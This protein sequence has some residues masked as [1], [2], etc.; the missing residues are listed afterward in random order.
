M[1]TS[2]DGTAAPVWG[3]LSDDARAVLG[4]LREFLDAEVR[5]GATHRDATGEFPRAIVDELA[6]LGLLGMQVPERYGG[7]GLDG[8]TAA[9]VIEEIAAADGSLCLTVA[10]HNSLCSGH[11][12]LAGSEAQ[13][14]RFLPPLARGERLG[15]WGLT[16]SGA[17]SDAA[18]L[19]TRATEEADGTFVI[20]GSKAFI[21]QGGVADTFVIV[22]R[23]DAPTEGAHPSD[24]VSAF[25]VDGDTPGLSRGLPEKKLG[26]KS[27]DTT[28]L[29]FEGMRVPGDRLLGTRGAAFRDVMR[30]LDAGR[31]GIAA[32]AIGLGRAA[33]DVA[34]RYA[35]EREAF[36][37]PIA[38]HQGVAFKL[39]EMATELDA[40]R[41]LTLRAAA[42]KDAGRDFVAAAARAKLFA[43][44]R[45]VQAC[46][47]A[48]QV[49]GGYGYIEEYEVGRLWRDAR[50]TRIGEGTDEIQ[51]LIIARAL[52]RH[53]AAGGRAIDLP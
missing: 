46:D 44:T 34:A 22:A 23:T 17:G 43:S 26:L 16:E 9:R 5:P 49:L 52:I 40:A 29:T 39:A 4:P 25:V 21:T 35:L 2:S 37:R 50:L 38:H 24:G 8:E 42:L 32:M 18:A 47:N 3:D 33:L 30:V 11:I 51:H 19:R 6:R 41:L 48:I 15:A 45:A 28:A 1:T 20:D 7:A 53:Y 13:L 36:G 27:S 14:E 31:I 10:S 12:M